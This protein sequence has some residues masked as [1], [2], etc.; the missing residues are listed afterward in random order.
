MA[1]KRFETPEVQQAEDKA[2]IAAVEAAAPKLATLPER[3]DRLEKVIILVTN[4]IGLR[5]GE[6]L[7]SN[8]A[9]IIEF[10]QAPGQARKK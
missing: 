6:P 8:F 1:R 2:P 4:E 7:K 3:I 9:H 5:L 10:A